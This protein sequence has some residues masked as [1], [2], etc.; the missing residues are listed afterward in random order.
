MISTCWFFI[1][2]RNWLIFILDRKIRYSTVDF[3]TE[4]NDFDLFIL[5]QKNVNATENKSTWFKARE[6]S[7][8]FISTWK[9]FVIKRNWLFFFVAKNAIFEWLV[10]VQKNW[11]WLFNLD[12]K[13][14]NATE[15]KSKCFKARVTA[16][17]LEI[18]FWCQN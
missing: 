12:Q 3:C 13:N 17:G 9:F 5:D 4:K 16:R 1:I 15:K 7:K 2:K 6:G 14:L 8:C 18:L 10:L 11:F